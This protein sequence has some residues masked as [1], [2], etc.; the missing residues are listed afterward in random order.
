MT[1]PGANEYENTILESDKIWKTG[2]KSGLLDFLSVFY[3]KH[4]RYQL[5]KTH[6]PNFQSRILR[7]VF[8]PCTVHPKR[9][10]NVITTSHQN[11]EKRNKNWSK[12]SLCQFNS[13]TYH[14]SS[15][16]SNKKQAFCIEPNTSYNNIYMIFIHYP[17]GQNQV[18]TLKSASMEIYIKNAELTWSRYCN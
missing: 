17:A 2:N 9:K 7:F 3:L 16:Q 18:P 15:V 8:L 5:K 14:N 13:K 4:I 1:R 12:Q 10:T 6:S 11:A